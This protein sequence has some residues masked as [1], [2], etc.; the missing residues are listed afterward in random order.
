[1]TVT[2]EVSTTSFVTVTMRA[3]AML[4]CIQ[5]VNQAW[6]YCICPYQS[7]GKCTTNTYCPD[8]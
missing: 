6:T 3:Y 1:M 5:T 8:L 4:L 7:Q 2:N